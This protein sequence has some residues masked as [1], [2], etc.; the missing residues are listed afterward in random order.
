MEPFDPAWEFE[1]LVLKLNKQHFPGSVSSGKTRNAL[2][3]AWALCVGR[4]RANT[5]LH[6]AIARYGSRNQLIRVIHIARS[7]L[8]EYER[9]LQDIPERGV[10]PQDAP[11]LRRA[12]NN[13]S[14][15]GQSDFLR[16]SAELL[17]DPSLLRRLAHGSNDQIASLLGGA[18]RTFDLSIAVDELADYL[19]GEF[20][21]EQVYQDW[22]DRHSWAFGNTHVLRDDVRRLDSENVVDMLL[23]DMVGFRDIVE[24]KR[25]DEVVL[26]WDR[27]HRTHYL[28]AGCSRAV[29]QVH[30]YMDR[31]HELAREGLVG[32]PHIVAYHPHATVVIGRS[33]NWSDAKTRALHGLNERLHGVSVITYDHLLARARRLLATVR[34]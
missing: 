2:I 17:R 9:F 31:L 24:L 1:T 13:L 4:Q 23:P 25:P 14:L 16:V 33:K 3:R 18:L 32:H 30:K 10:L 29:G 34:V 12:F 28:S 26:C 27:S 22:C 7:T 8:V 21:R 6:E 20:V 15:D 19:D 11:A 5:E